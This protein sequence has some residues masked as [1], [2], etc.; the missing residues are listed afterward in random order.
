MKRGSHYVWKIGLLIFVVVMSITCL[1]CYL[2]Y[3]SR[4]YSDFTEKWINYKY[5]LENDRI[6]ENGYMQV[7]VDNN[8]INIR[9]ADFKYDYKIEFDGVYGRLYRKSI[10]Y[11]NHNVSFDYCDNID[12]VLVT[13]TDNLNGII[14]ITLGIKSD[15]PFFI[16]NDSKILSLMNELSGGLVDLLK[17]RD[18]R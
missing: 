11:D 7:D 16:Y 9:N 2:K 14:D 13:R 5:D 6:I 12:C 4:F 15:I 18:A 17:D 8:T 1:I 3:K 10:K